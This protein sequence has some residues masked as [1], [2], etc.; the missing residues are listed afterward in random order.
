MKIVISEN[1]QNSKEEILELVRHFEEGGTLLGPGKRN[2]IKLFELQGITVNVKAFKMPN[3]IN[4]IVYRF[5]RR[6]KAERSYT[7]AQKL[8]VKGIGTPRP[9]AYLEETG[10]TT[11][12]KSYYI[13]EQLGYDLTYR[14]LVQQADYPHHEEIL[15]AFTRF[16]FRLHEEG[17]EFLDHSPGNTLIQLNSG[18]YRFFLVDLNRMNFKKLSLEERMR[19]FSRLTPRKDMVKVMASEYAKLISMPEELVFQKMWGYTSDFQRDFQRKK[20]LKKKV[21]FWKK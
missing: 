8:L 14:E 15:R 10:A 2:K 17:V 19:N 5:F 13:S 7:Y 4:R 3:L 1:F 21:K 9:I 16:T 18:D 12:R 20:A 11:F 6:S